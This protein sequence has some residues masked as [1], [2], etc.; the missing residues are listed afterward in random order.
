MI[1]KIRDI[2]KK[3]STYLGVTVV[4]V[5][6]LL[7]ALSAKAQTFDLTPNASTTEA[8]GEVSD[9]IESYAGQALAFVVEIFGAMWYWFLLIGAIFF[10]IRWLRNTGGHK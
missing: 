4:S 1:Q 7:T 6:G 9:V 10:V 3:S 2:F 8:V 5:G